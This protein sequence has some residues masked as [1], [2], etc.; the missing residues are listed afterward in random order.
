MESIY[1]IL[2]CISLCRFD[3]LIVI[4]GRFV[5]REKR[6]TADLLGEKKGT[7]QIGIVTCSGEQVPLMFR[8]Q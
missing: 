6:Y 2:K 5:Q 8:A 4:H 3:H 1:T 7:R